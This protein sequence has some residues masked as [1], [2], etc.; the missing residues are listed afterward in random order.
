MS[1]WKNHLRIKASGGI[2]RPVNLRN[3]D[4][5]NIQDLRNLFKK[6]RSH[7]HKSELIDSLT[8]IELVLLANNKAEAFPLKCQN[9]YAICISI[10]L[11]RAIWNILILSLCDHKIFP[12]YG[13]E[14][15]AY[16]VR[17]KLS[18]QMV[19]GPSV[20]PAKNSQQY[21]K[22][23]DRQL[24][25]DITTSRKELCELLFN[26]IMDYLLYHEAMHITRDHLSFIHIFNN[27][28]FIDEAKTSS[29]NDINF[30]QFLEI[31]ADIVSLQF[32]LPTNPE[33]KNFNRLPEFNKEDF[34]FS[35]MFSNIIIQQLF[36]FNNEALSIS[37]QWKQY[38]P[39]PVVRSILYDN[40]LHQ[41]FLKN[42]Q[43]SDDRIRT[44]Q[45][46]AWWEAGQIAKKLGFPL[47][48]WHGKKTDSISFQRIHH[49]INQFN[50]FQDAI[51]RSH[52]SG[53]Y[54]E[55]KK[56]MKKL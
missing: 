16:K 4:R 1:I 22:G 30:F 18:S 26:S 14:Y 17:R 42:S 45:K 25:Q 9:K 46:K 27:Q 6:L 38:H 50:N 41:F 8:D 47:G 28:D 15:R 51:E 37:S 36:D 20:T 12:N 39:P 49:F 43:L 11:V 56:L 21:L 24:Y 55:I 35:Q 23:T 54:T 32:M 13:G 31:D 33:L 2:F 3:V 7:L 44:Q 10:G 19:F 53:S 40:L 34:I 29:T 48:R 52:Q 5:S